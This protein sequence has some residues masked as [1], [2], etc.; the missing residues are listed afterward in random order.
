M[1][2][3]ARPVRA[4]MGRGGSRNQITGGVDLTWARGEMKG[5][6]GC[7]LMKGC[8]Q[9]FHVKSCTWVGWSTLTPILNEYPLFLPKVHRRGGYDGRLP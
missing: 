5:W 3:D 1:I 9:F 2:P 7:Q 8:M 6:V 4:G